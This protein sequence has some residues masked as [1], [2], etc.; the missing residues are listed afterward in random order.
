MTDRA[1]AEWCT[2]RVC[3]PRTPADRRRLSGCALIL[4]GLAAGTLATGLVDAAIAG[5]GL[6]VIIG[7]ERN[8]P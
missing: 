1:H 3:T 2:C 7:E 8:R 5:P 6:G 4:A